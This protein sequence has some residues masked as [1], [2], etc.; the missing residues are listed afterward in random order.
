V[1]TPARDPWWA[2]NW[3]YRRDDQYLPRLSCRKRSS[4]V[5]AQICLHS[6]CGRRGSFRDASQVD[7]NRHVFTGED[8]AEF[9]AQVPAEPPSEVGAK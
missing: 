2:E 7:W 4:P 8:A 1:S 3:G 6:A 9:D 5:P